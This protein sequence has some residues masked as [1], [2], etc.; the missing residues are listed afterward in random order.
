MSIRA[1]D[2]ADL[3]DDLGLER[4]SVTVKEG[5]DHDQ[6][7]FLTFGPMAYRQLVEISP[8]ADIDTVKAKLEAARTTQLV[9]THIYADER[10]KKLEADLLKK[11]AGTPLPAKVASPPPETKSPPAATLGTAKGKRKAAKAS[12]E[13]T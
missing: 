7:F 13:R 2:I 8:K 6:Q 1:R 4:A 9:E 12:D 10:R 11:I 3:C 5:W